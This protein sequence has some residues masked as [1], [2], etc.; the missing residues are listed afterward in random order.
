MPF[1]HPKCCSVPLLWWFSLCDYCYCAATAG[2][3]GISGLSSPTLH[4]KD[5]KVVFKFL[6][7]LRQRQNQMV[8]GKAWDILFGR[9]FHF[10]VRYDHFSF[11]LWEWLTG[12]LSFWCFVLLVLCSFGLNPVDLLEGG[13]TFNQCHL[14]D[15]SEVPMVPARG[16]QLDFA[17]GFD[18]PNRSGLLI[19]LAKAI[20]TMRYEFVCGEWAT[21]IA[22]T[23]GKTAAGR[24]A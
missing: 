8:T 20:C 19:A 18:R 4:N 17:S 21:E 16:K 24:L 3:N 6:L 10:T 2:M 7:K 23:K 12:V 13:L 22:R 11:L 14:V 15:T 5:D 1:E 9:D